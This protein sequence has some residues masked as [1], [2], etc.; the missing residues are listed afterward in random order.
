MHMSPDQTSGMDIGVCN[1][2]V[3]NKSFMSL[4]FLDL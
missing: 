3:L 1:N 4:S 2:W